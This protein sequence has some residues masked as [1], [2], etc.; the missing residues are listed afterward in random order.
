MT[1]H[2]YYIPKSLVISSFL[3]NVYFSQKLLLKA[4]EIG[5]LHTICQGTLKYSDSLT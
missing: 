2:G 5:S 1:S 3:K 4:R